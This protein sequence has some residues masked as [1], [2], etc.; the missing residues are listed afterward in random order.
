MA[1]QLAHGTWYTTPAVSFSGM[2]SFGLTSNCFSVPFGLKGTVMPRGSGCVL[3]P[4]RHLTR[5]GV[6]HTGLWFPSGRHTNKFK[7][8]KQSG[9]SHLGNI[10][11]FYQNL[12][13]SSDQI[14]FL[15][16]CGAME[17][18][19]KI[20]NMRDGVAVRHSIAI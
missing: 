15:K 4:L 5:R 6:S 7:E 19:T 18:C 10:L 13:V 20:V 14:C 17:G 2:Q 11:W 12:M 1:G 16:N 8:L 3:P 9:D